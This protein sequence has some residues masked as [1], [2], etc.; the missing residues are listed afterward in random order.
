M[1]AHIDY[2]PCRLAYRVFAPR[3]YGPKENGLPNWIRGNERADEASNNMKT[4]QKLFKE[5]VELER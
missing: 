3:N 4:Q 2:S 1:A 5:G